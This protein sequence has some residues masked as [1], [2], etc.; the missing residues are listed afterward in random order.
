MRLIILTFQSFQH[1]MLGAAHHTKEQEEKVRAILHDWNLSDKA[2]MGDLSSGERQKAHLTRLLM[3]RGGWSFLDEPTS[4][5]DRKSIDLFFKHMVPTYAAS[6]KLW[7]ASHDDH[8][9]RPYFEHCLIL[10]HGTCIHAGPWN[11]E[12][13]SVIDAHL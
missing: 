9:L 8:R 10:Q 12:A 3:G 6:K 5:L 7:I 4:Y 11:T 2:R 13:Q 1:V